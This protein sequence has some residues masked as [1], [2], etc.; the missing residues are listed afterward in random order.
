MTDS[1]VDWTIAAG[2]TLT[3]VAGSF[4]SMAPRFRRF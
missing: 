3:A 1:V 2:I 4:L